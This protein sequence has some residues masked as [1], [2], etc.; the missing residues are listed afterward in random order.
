MTK[1]G[2]TFAIAV[3]SL[4]SPAATTRSPTVP[5]HWMQHACANSPTPR[6]FAGTR[7]AAQWKSPTQW[8]NAAERCG[9]GSGP[10]A[11]PASSGSDEV[12]SHPGLKL[13]IPA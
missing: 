13:K 9:V 12:R 8:K 7:S 1:A 3:A 5:R 4:T 6:Q 11:G 10:A 2:S